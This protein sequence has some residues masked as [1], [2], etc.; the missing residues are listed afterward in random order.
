MLH[1]GHLVA[2]LVAGLALTLAAPSTIAQKRY[3]P[4]AS[5][6]EIRIGQTMPYSGPASAYG[7]IGRVHA[8]Y[9]RKI[10]DEGGI[11]GRQIRLISLDDSYSPP[12]TMEMVRRLVEQDQ[13]LLLFGMVG[14]AS[15]SAVHKY[16][17]EHRVPH[18]LVNAGAS[19]F[20]DPK[21][22]PWT[23]AY[24]AN[25]S[26]EAQVYA[27]HILATKPEAKIAVLFQNDDFGKDYLAG[28]KEAMGARSGQIVAQASYEVS[29]PT[30]DSQVVTLKASGA[31]VLFNVS[32]PKFAAMAIRKVYEIGWKPLHYLVAPGSP[33]RSV[34]VPAGVDRSI[35][36]ITAVGG[37]D[38]VDPQWND[39]PGMTD[40]RAFMKKYYP[41]GDPDDNLNSAG[42]NQAVLMVQVLRACGDDLTR[43]NLLR[44]AT[45]LKDVQLPLS[46]P[47]ALVS[48]GPDDYRLVK[49]LQ[50]RRFDGQ[51][52]VPISDLIRIGGQQ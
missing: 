15:N 5:D 35:G 36:V 13:V 41:E 20:T 33:I 1:I 26:L 43:E 39:D 31:D 4:G 22:H 7:T 8:A 48:T 10:N 16:V 50:M 38:P 25:Y 47:G 45:T 2:T 46:L 18:L 14:T 3:G 51:R 11:N 9:F 30:V 34:L 49:T 52:Y 32:S 42:Y 24:I 44:Q 29:D 23:L 37:K 6:T 40:Y 27:R 28:F 17:N 12:K 19:K 21:G